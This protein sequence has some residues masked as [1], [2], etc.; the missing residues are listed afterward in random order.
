VDKK[1]W[2]DLL[3]LEHASME[4]GQP[5]NHVNRWI[6]FIDGEEL[7]F[8]TDP[9]LITWLQENSWEEAL[10]YIKKKGGDSGVIVEWSFHRRGRFQLISE[11]K[12][13]VKDFLIREN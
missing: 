4:D 3:A 1:Y 13:P 7:D 2:Q 6:K 12:V 9:V 11:E 5:T 8:S 10:M